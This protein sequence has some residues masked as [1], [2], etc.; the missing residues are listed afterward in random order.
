VQDVSQP[1]SAAIG[2]SPIAGALP[3]VRVHS[4]PLPCPAK[5]ASIYQHVC[6]LTSRAPQRGLRPISPMQDKQSGR[7]GLGLQPP[8]LGVRRPEE[9]TGARHAV[10]SVDN[11]QL[12]RPLRLPPSPA[13]TCPIGGR[14]LP[15]LPFVS[16]GALKSLRSVKSRGS[17]ACAG[18]LAPPEAAVAASGGGRWRRRRQRT[19]DATLA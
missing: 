1:G 19:R 17:A 7:G 13:I 18:R 8:A 2:P 10:P 3:T 6:R 16:R 4:W 5:V 14:S 12:V 11:R 9:L 15:P